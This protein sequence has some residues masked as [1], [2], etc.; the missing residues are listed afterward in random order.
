MATGWL[1]W[2]PSDALNTPIPQIRIA[3]EAHIEKLIAVNGGGA[4]RNQTSPAQKP[5]QKPAV[6]SREAVAD[7]VK[8]LFRSKGA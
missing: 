1:G 4:T 5:K 8:Q 2:S 6:M 7:T 3:Y